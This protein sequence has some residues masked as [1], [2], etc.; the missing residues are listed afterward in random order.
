MTMQ[1]PAKPGRSK[2]LQTVHLL[3]AALAAIVIAVT[4]QG[5]PSPIA[6]CEPGPVCDGI[7]P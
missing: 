1:N 7:R 5:W 3:L 6:P 4:S 2:A